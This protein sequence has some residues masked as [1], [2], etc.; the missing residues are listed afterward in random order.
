[1]SISIFALRGCDCMPTQKA[2]A[3]PTNVRIFYDESGKQSEKLH[4]MGAVLIPERVYLEKN[5]HSLLNDIIKEGKNHYI[6]QILT[7][8]VKALKDSKHLFL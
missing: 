6:L 2:I 5:N 7:V 1:M 3:T 8:T 4:F